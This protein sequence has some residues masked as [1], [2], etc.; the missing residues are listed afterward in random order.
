MQE[1]GIIVRRNGKLIMFLQVEAKD[2]APSEEGFGVR[3]RIIRKLIIVMVVL[4]WAGSRPGEGTG[5]VQA[6]VHPA[7]SQTV[8]VMSYNIHWGEGLD[9]RYDLDRIARVIEQVHPDI[10]G[11]QEVNVHWDDRS[12]FDDQ[13]QWLARTLHMHAFFAPIYSKGTAPGKGIGV[14][15]DAAGP[16]PQ[17]GDPSPATGVAILTR[18]PILRAQNHAICRLST[19]EKA[20]FPAWYPGFADVVV[21]IG[22]VSVRVYNTHLDYRRN[23]YI[24]RLQVRDMLSIIDRQPEP[25]WQILL[26]DLNA[27]P[28]APELAPLWKRF[29]NP[30]ESDPN[31]KTYPADV[32]SRRIDYVLVSPGLEVKKVW[33]PETTA[34]DHRPV[35]AVVSVGT[36][37]NPVKGHAGSRVPG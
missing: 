34:S 18:Y 21:Q 15:P 16:F 26:G 36:R 19:I 14:R 10:V 30:R 2:C 32:P 23:P 37:S 33:I 28:N 17:T 11:L 27:E 22:G 6:A 3:R 24:R 35:A 4:C 29:S 1:Q 12:R 5:P 9:G 20:L 8:T 7:A 25:A 13:V 31:L